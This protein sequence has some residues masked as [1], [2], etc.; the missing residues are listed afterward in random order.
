MKKTII[1][2]TGLT[3]D[4]GINTEKHPLN[5]VK[6]AIKIIDN[7][8]KYKQ[9][10]TSNSPQFVSTL[11]YYGRQEG[12]KVFLYLNKKRA[13]LEKVFKDWNKCYDL[14]DKMIKD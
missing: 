7:P 4:K 3:V 9:I 13:T 2:Y 5:Q 1:I 6:K 11:Y 12:F 14:M 8:S 10:F